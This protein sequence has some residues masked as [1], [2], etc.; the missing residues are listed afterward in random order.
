MFTEHSSCPGTHRR[1]HV[2]LIHSPLQ[3]LPGEPY[4][5]CFKAECCL[6]PPILLS[7]PEESPETW[8]C[9]THCH[10]KSHQSAFKCPWAR[11]TRQLPV[12][13]VPFPLAETLNNSLTLLVKGVRKSW[14]EPVP[15]GKGPSCHERLGQSRAMRSTGRGRSCPQTAPVIKAAVVPGH[16]ASGVWCLLVCSSVALKTLGLSEIVLS[17][18]Y[19][20]V[21][22]AVSVCDWHFRHKIWYCSCDAAPRSCSIGKVCTFPWSFI[23][24]DEVVT[25]NVYLLHKFHWENPRQEK[26][27]ESPTDHQHYNFHGSSWCPSDRKEEVFLWKSRI[28]E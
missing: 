13:N 19:P 23:S 24:W 15:I 2:L 3:G 26:C 1:W 25:L 8:N 5:A 6:F 16:G 28:S 22:E 14:T 9:L 18:L 20:F 7:F 10:E 17:A 11:S 4:I 21:F 27:S 12:W